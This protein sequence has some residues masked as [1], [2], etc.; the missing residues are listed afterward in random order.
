MTTYK[1]WLLQ[2][3][4]LKFVNQ[5]VC[6]SFKE[7]HGVLVYTAHYKLNVSNYVIQLSKNNRRLFAYQRSQKFVG[8]DTQINLYLHAPAF[9]T[10]RIKS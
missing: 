7:S 3:P 6:R 9:D 2:F 8:F 1:S 10:W 5:I 4:R